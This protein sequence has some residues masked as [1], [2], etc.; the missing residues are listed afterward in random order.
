MTRHTNSLVV[1]GDGDDIKRFIDYRDAFKLNHDLAG[2]GIHDDVNIT[3]I[4]Q[5]IVVCATKVVAP[6]VSTALVEDILTTAIAK[7]NPDIDATNIA[8]S[9]FEKPECDKSRLRLTTEMLLDRVINEKGRRV[10]TRAYA[11]SYNIKDTPLAIKTLINRYM[12]KTK[13]PNFLQRPKFQALMERGFYKLIGASREQV[14]TKDPTHS[15]LYITPEEL[16]EASVDYLCSLQAKGLDDKTMKELY[17]DF[18]DFESPVVLGFFM[19]HQV[20]YISGHGWDEK[21]KAGQGISAWPKS[22]QLMHAAYARCLM[23]RLTTLMSKRIIIATG[24]AEAEIS[25]IASELLA[26]E[27][28]D[29]LYKFLNDFTQWDS[30]N[31]EGILSFECWVLS[32]AGMPDVL[33]K[34]YR[35]N[36]SQWKQV[37][38]TDDGTV[39]LDG[40]WKQHSGIAYTLLFNTINNACLCAGFIEWEGLVFAAFKGDD[41]I[42]IAKHITIDRESEQLIGECGMLMKAHLD[43]TPEFTGFVLTKHGYFPDVVKKAARVLTKKIIDNKYF[44]DLRANVKADLACVT[45]PEAMQA[46][47]FALTQHYREEGVFFSTHDIELIYFYLQDFVDNVQFCDLVEDTRVNITMDVE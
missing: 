28:W 31:H 20:K 14:V 35:L 30:T 16:S 47:I 2:C 36:K 1:Y 15:L 33:V 40:L 24:R 25:Q 13:N 9:T 41:S 44:E 17:S 6:P 3:T 4:P 42:I 10:G 29:N 32:L 22:E 23:D 8:T 18:V 21:E 45:T 12:K 19:K 26:S 43:R 5:K 37:M 38:H 11:K 39:V 7:A 34:R 46:G 27:D